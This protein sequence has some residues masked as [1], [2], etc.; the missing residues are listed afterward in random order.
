MIGKL[1]WIWATR[2]LGPTPRYT[3]S[4]HVIVYT[5]GYYAA[6]HNLEYTGMV[7]D[8]PDASRQKLRDLIKLK[9]SQMRLSLAADGFP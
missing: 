1:L 7:L 3:I 6:F 2:R 8:V 5:D 9:Q 4:D